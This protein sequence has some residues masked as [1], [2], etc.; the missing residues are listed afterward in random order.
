[1]LRAANSN[2]LTGSDV[3]PW[4]IKATFTVIDDQGKASDQGTYEEFWA[5]PTKNKMIVSGSSY[6]RTDVHTAA[7]L[8]RSGTLTSAQNITAEARREF[9]EP[10]PTPAMIAHESFEFEQKQVGDSKLSCLKITGL[11]ANPGLVYCLGDDKPLL[12]LSV[13]GFESLQV[14]HSR[15]LSFQGRYIAGDLQFLHNSKL[16]GTAHLESIEALDP[17]NESDFQPPSDAKPVSLKV[18]ISSGVAGGMLK[19]SRSPNYPPQAIAAGTQ[20]SVVLAIVIATD[21][22]VSDV[23]VVSGPDIFRQPAIDAVRKWVYRP[24]LLNG[25]PTEVNTTAYVVFSLEN[26]RPA[27][28]FRD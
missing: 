15:I 3:Q 26:H 11:P 21:G 24:Y 9:V 25:Q 17:I 19:E 10:L 8:V 13:I 23:H 6:S 4:H 5:G 12:R 7:G 14:V 16:A 28:K 1:M 22:H 18:T 2:N 27:V 20:G